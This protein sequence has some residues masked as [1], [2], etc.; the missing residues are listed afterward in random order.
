MKTL[1][2]AVFEHDGNQFIV[3]GYCY[4]PAEHSVPPDRVMFLIELEAVYLGCKFVG[5][6]KFD[7]NDSG[8]L[9]AS[10][11]EIDLV[12]AD[13]EKVTVYVISGPIFDNSESVH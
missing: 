4:N 6:K 5:F 13:N 9:V 2:V 3:S 1:N 10:A 12:S 11:V 7:Y 8:Q